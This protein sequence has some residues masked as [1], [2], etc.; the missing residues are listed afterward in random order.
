MVRHLLR[1]RAVNRADLWGIP[2]LNKHFKKA[3]L[4]AAAILGLGAGNAQ[5][6]FDYIDITT[7]NNS[8]SV[9]VP[10]IN[11]FQANLASQGVTSFYLGR[12]LQVTGARAGDTIEV[13]FFAAE[14]GYWNTFDFGSA[15]ISNLGNRSWAERDVGT[16][17]ASNGILS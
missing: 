11:N 15:D 10:V 8:L 7:P 9:P 12:S 17:A 1:M 13:D 14:A 5:A 6:A 3:A 16:V 2:V 4:S